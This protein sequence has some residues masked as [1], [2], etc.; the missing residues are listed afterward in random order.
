MVTAAR[1]RAARLGRPGPGRDAAYSFLRPA[2]GLTASLYL[3]ELYVAAAYR[4]A[5][6]GRLLMDELNKI[7]AR[8]G[9]SRMEWTVRTRLSGARPSRRPSCSAWSPNS[10]TS[11]SGPTPLTSSFGRAL[12]DPALTA[13]R[14]DP[15]RVR[16]SQR[17]LANRMAC[18]LTALRGG[19]R[20]ADAKSYALA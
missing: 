14:G 10:R 9:L 19:Y 7:A 3:K 17:T 11:G 15:E 5:G 18:N 13:W 2:A 1:L 4:R 12:V 6:V 8:R 20:P 16:G